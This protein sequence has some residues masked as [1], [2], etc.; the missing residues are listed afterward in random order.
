MLPNFWVILLY[1]YEV[2]LSENVVFVSA[3]LVFCLCYAWLLSLWMVA[4]SQKRGYHD[5][6]AA[7]LEHI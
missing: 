7:L 1:Y 6:G 4:K 2:G 3:A 5:G